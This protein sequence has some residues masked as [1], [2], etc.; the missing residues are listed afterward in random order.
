MTPTVAEALWRGVGVALL[1]LFEDGGDDPPRV[2]VAATAEHAARLVSFGVR[3]VLV[4]GT[5]GE[6]EALDD[7]ERVELIAAVRQACPGVPVM[8]GASGAWIGEAVARSAGAVK[9]G[10]DAVL[11]APPRRCLDPVG[12]YDGVARASGGVPVVAYHFPGVAGGEVAVDDL[13]RLPVAG[14]KDSSG[15]PERLL[16][17]L[18]NWAG[19]IYVGSTVLVGYA[20]ALGAAGAI[21]AVANAAPEEC[22]AAWEG[23]WSAQ[24]RLLAAHQAA[25]ARFPLGLKQLVADRFGTATLRRSLKD[26][27]DHDVS[28]VNRPRS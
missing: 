27:H 24:R 7:D 18:E 2:D 20:G 15:D 25:R 9:A 13:A 12:W 21:L 22:V 4:A 6:A 14:L 26:R 3:G 23:D 16:A 5:T 17:A 8:A 10:A 1:T 19:S 11:V 28:V